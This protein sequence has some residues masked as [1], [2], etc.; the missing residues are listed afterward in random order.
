VVPLDALD[1][2]ARTEDERDPL[3]QLVRGDVE[4]P[5]APGARQAACGVPEVGLSL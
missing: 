1:L 4:N 2:L 3:V 5:L